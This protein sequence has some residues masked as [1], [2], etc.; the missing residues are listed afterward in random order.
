MQSFLLYSLRGRF[1]N[2]F[3]AADRQWDRIFFSWSKSRVNGTKKPH[4]P[5]KLHTRKQAKQR[6]DRDPFFALSGFCWRHELIAK[7]GQASIRLPIVFAMLQHTAARAFSQLQRVPCCPSLEM[8]ARCPLER[9]NLAGILQQGGSIVR[10]AMGKCLL[11]DFAWGDKKNMIWVIPQ[12]DIGPQISDSITGHA[13]RNKKEKS[14]K[15]LWIVDNGRQGR[16]WM[17]KISKRRWTRMGAMIGIMNW[18]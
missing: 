17:S 12:H 7:S 5:K 2:A 15:W 10:P 9:G 3:A 4:I 11:S 6:D 18:W 14:I 1:Q 16:G 13:T 8:L